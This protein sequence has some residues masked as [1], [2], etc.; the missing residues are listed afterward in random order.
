MTLKEFVNQKVQGF[1]KEDFSDQRQSSKCYEGTDT[2]ICYFRLKRDFTLSN[3]TVVN[4]MLI[5]K[6]LLE[7]AKANELK[8]TDGEVVQDIDNDVLRV[9]L[10]DT[11]KKV[12][13]NSMLNW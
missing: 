10:P 1:T 6:N 12:D 3:G 8:L 7:K 2:N 5:S 4:F 11:T 13:L 9:Q